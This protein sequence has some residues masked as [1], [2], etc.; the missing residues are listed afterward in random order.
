[1]SLN[2][3]Y[4]EVSVYYNYVRFFIKG[5]DFCIDLIQTK[6]GVTSLD[7][8]IIKFSKRIPMKNTGIKEFINKREDEVLNESLQK[9]KQ[10]IN[11]IL[12]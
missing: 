6:M 4:K 8:E 3:L 10:E 11:T 9:I 12:D 5:D 7:E 2:E 1:M